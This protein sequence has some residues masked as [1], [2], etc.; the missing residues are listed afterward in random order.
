MAKK[1]MRSL[2]EEELNEIG[3]GDHLWNQLHEGTQ[4][5]EPEVAEEVSWVR[6]ALYDCLA[7]MTD[8][9]YTKDVDDLT[10]LRN[11]AAWAFHYRQILTIHFAELRGHEVDPKERERWFEVTKSDEW[12][13][14]AERFSR[15][16]GEAVH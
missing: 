6:L 11:Y 10:K 12:R 1:K 9:F 13:D 8:W 3:R 2:T 16:K 15:P 14:M 5:M 7:C 4:A